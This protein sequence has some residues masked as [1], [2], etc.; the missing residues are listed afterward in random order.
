MSPVES[1]A[2]FDGAIMV[3]EILCDGCVDCGLVTGKVCQAVADLNLNADVLSHHDPRRHDSGIDCDG[4]LKIRINGLVVSAK[5][6]CSV[7]D[8]MLIFSK[9]PN[10]YS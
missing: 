4:L 8:L 9:E 5:S 6:D 10:L 7:R 2:F 1:G 3:I